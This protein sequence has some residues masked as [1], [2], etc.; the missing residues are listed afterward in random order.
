MFGPLGWFTVLHTLLSLLAIVLGVLAL[1][2]LGKGRRR[3]GVGTAFL[4]AAFLASAT[5]FVFPFHGATPAIAVG[6]VA[7][8]VLAWTAITRRSADS[9]Q[10]PLGM[11]ISEYLLVFVLVAQL[12]AKLPV[13]AALPPNVQKPLFG[14]AQL[15]VL[16]LFVVAAFRLVRLSRAQGRG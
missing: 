10:F 12:F 13:L 11:V 7:L 6:I 14:M 16:V 8:L 2:D 15:L 9:V 1:V 3:S 4:V 5:G